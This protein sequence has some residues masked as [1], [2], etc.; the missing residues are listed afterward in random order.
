MLRFVFG[1]LLVALISQANAGDS[2]QARA[3]KKA[4]EELAEATLKGDDGKLVDRTFDKIVEMAGGREKMI[5]K[6]SEFRKSLEAK[7]VKIHSLKIGAPGEVL[8]EGKYVFVVVPTVMEMRV[9]KASLT[10]KSFLLG[11]SSDDGKSWKFVEG[12]KVRDQAAREK[13]LPALPKRLSLPPMEQP[14]ITRDD[15]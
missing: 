11:I 10:G 8:K 13:V 3:A 6:I 2:S 5:L 1:F 7:G 9:P 14:M 15:A 4:A 12:V